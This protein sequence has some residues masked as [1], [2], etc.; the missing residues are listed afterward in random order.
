MNYRLTIRYTSRGIA[1]YPVR[2]RGTQFDPPVFSLGSH[3]GLREPEGLPGGKPKGCGGMVVVSRGTSRDPSIFTY[4]S[5]GN[6]CRPI[7][8]HAAP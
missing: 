4:N 3:G 7:G 5:Y 1:W 8:T 6:P 2:P